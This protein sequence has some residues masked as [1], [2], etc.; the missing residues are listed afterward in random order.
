M[1][2]LLICAAVVT[3]IGP[4][5]AFA[6]TL[7]GGTIRRL[8]PALDAIVPAN[9]KLEVL[10]ADYF[11]SSE[12]PVW[13]SEGPTGFLLFTDQAANRIY[14]WMPDGELSVFL[15]PAGYTGD[16]AKW[17]E[18]A[19]LFYNERLF[20]GLVGPNGLA[21]DREGRL[22]ICARGDRAIVRLEKNASRTTLAD[23]Y[24]GQRLLSPNDLVVKSDGSIYFSAPGPPPLR[25]RPNAAP[26]GL[27]R[28]HNGAVQLLATRDTLQGGSPNGLAFSPDEK[29]LYVVAAGTIWRF[30]VQPD[31]TIADGRFF[32]GESGADGM[33]VDRNGNLYFG[34]PDGLWIVTPDGKHLGT[35][36]MGRFTNLAFGNLDR[37]TLY[38]TIRRGLARIRLNVPGI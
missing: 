9:A 27:Y 33:K 34:G 38:I 32:V 4:G 6:Q 10:K 26:S 20:L 1:K 3:S 17:P 14:K 28:W 36:A 31:G 5:L 18:V 7:S 22:I 19:R 15:D 12:G 2:K 30:D 24:E 25:T 35:I 37:K 23:R 13:I 16:R 11:G 8:D 21:V 29:I